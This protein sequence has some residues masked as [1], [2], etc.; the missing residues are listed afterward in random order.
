MT[1]LGPI[2]VSSVVG[3]GV[4]AVCMQ[5]LKPL[6]DPTC[7]VTSVVLNFGLS[8]HDSRQLHQRGFSVVEFEFVRS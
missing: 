4:G 3:G 2:A 7:Y 6:S 5:I 8:S 1:R